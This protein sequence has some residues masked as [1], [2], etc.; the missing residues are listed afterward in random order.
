MTPLSTAELE[1]GLDHIRRS[2]TEVGTVELIVRRPAEG[3][4]EILELAELDVGAGLVGD[5]WLRRGSSRFGDAP[6]PEAELTVMNARSVALVAQEPQ[7]WALAGD[8]VYVDLDLSRTHLPA[9]TRLA[10]GGAI[11][12]VSKPPHTG[13]AKFAERFGLDA[14]RFVNSRA[15]R[16]LRLRGMNAKVVRSGPVRTGD[17][18]QKINEPGVPVGAGQSSRAPTA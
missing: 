16:E 1:A 2:P 5:D 10:L 13:C 3:E 18:V 12:E 7:R 14:L 4:R 6:D 15:G 11:I 17:L 8:Q 9:G